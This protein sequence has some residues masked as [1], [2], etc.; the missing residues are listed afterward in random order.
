MGRPAELD[1]RTG[2]SVETAGLFIEGVDPS[3]SE[4]IPNGVCGV[5]TTNDGCESPVLD[6]LVLVCP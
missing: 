4:C 6:R 5:G 2:G 3:M 1:D